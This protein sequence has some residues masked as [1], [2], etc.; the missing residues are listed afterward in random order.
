[1]CY[2]SVSFNITSL[3]MNHKSL[4]FQIIFLDYS[5]F[6][7]LLSGPSLFH[8]DYKLIP[9]V[10]FRFILVMLEFVLFDFL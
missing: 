8:L 2:F 1:M 7:T 6:Y 10:Q 5:S 3:V 4:N 9:S